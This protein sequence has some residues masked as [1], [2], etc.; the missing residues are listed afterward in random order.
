MNFITPKVKV[1][2]WFGE[3]LGPFNEVMATKD[4]VTRYRDVAVISEGLTKEAIVRV[5]VVVTAE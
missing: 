3:L 4:L 1:G 5:V 2:T